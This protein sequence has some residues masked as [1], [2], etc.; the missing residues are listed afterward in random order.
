MSD[1]LIVAFHLLRIGFLTLPMLAACACPNTVML[2]PGR[3]NVLPQQLPS[4]H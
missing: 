2:A 3:S 1:S 4:H